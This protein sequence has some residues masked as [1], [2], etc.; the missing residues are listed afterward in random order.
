VKRVFSLTLPQ[1]L[2]ECTK[3]VQK[4]LNECKYPS[5]I[6]RDL[7]QK[8]CNNNNVDQLNIA[9]IINND[10][11]LGTNMA[12]KTIQNVPGLTDKIVRIANS[13]DEAVKIMFSYKNV[14]RDRPYNT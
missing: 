1:N 3:I 13:I 10:T 6:I 5:Y 14:I 11:H 12:I 4:Q 7:I 9:V 2:D 8:Y